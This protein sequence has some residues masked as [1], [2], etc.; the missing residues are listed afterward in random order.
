MSTTSDP[1]SSPVITDGGAATPG[2]VLELVVPS[3][4]ARTRADR[5]VVE[6][7]GKAGHTTARADVQRWMRSALVQVDGQ[8]VQPKTILRAGMRVTVTLGTPPLTEAEPD[9]SVVFDVVFEDAHLLVVDK[10][11]G[12]VV[13]PAR[14]HRS[15]TLVNGLLARGGFA[16]ASADPRDPEGHLR[17][18]IVQRLDKDTSGLMVIAKDAPTREG[19]KAL[20]SRH[21]VERRY[22]AI[23][24]GETTRASYDTPH[25]RHRRSRLRFTSKLPDNRPGVRRARTQVEPLRRFAGATLV[26]CTLDTG[27]T[28]QIRVHLAEQARTPILADSL[29]GAPPPTESLRRIADTLGRQALHA[30]VLGFVHPISGKA[31]RWQQPVPA[32]MQQALDELT[33][34]AT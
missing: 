27:R 21:D 14:G 8:P 31:M 12:L 34:L 4:H 33:K 2:Q 3:E 32:D 6:L 7:L 5:V 29:Y 26:G 13:H 30:E 9:P 20:L 24:V 25:G 11:P 19:L 18:G 15:G 17:P 22:L 16:I 28:H 10:P 23:T 1:P